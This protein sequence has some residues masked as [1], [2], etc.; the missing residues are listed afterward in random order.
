MMDCL[1]QLACRLAGLGCWDELFG[2][3]L[4]VVLPRAAGLLQRMVYWGTVLGYGG[5][6]LGLPTT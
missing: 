5:Y 6:V 1:H 3:P 2:V 4:Y